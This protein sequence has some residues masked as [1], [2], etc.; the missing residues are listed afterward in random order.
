MFAPILSFSSQ[1]WTLLST[2]TSSRPKLSVTT[3]IILVLSTLLQCISQVSCFSYSS[4][5]PDPPRNLTIGRITSRRATVHWQTSE[6]QDP[7]ITRLEMTIKSMYD[8][9]GD[10]HYSEKII[11]N[12]DGSVQSFSLTDLYPQTEYTIHMFS[13]NPEG[14]SNMS[15]TITF[16][17]LPG[18]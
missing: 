12:I 3:P 18:K 11:T 1:C 13:F 9:L 17:T 5:L 2:K 4:A 6:G 16:K 7:Q 10:Q 8:E 15:D 14:M